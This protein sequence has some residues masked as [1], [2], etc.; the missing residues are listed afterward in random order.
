MLLKQ[1]Y[2]MMKGN[3]SP[4]VGAMPRS[5]VSDHAE[6]KP[7]VIPSA[8]AP[9]TAMH[10]AAPVKLNSQV[11]TTAG[12]GVGGV[13]LGSY[14]HQCFCKGFGDLCLKLK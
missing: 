12:K 2:S 7:S 3:R 6:A 13:K 10:N 8:K 11:S 9:Q 5:G 4:K 14:L 1:S